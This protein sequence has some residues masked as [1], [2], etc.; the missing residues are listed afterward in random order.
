M[1]LGVG[2]HVQLLVLRPRGMLSTQL[3]LP[4]LLNTPN[5]WKSSFTDLESFTVF[6]L[7]SFLIFSY[8]FFLN[9]YCHEYYICPFPPL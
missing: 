5:L 4:L 8:V 3:R 2:E 7:F 9:L 6:F 1:V